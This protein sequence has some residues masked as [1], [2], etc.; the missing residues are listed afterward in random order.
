[1]NKKK[2]KTRDYIAIAITI[3]I[4]III[5]LIGRVIY[6]NIVYKNVAPNIE[7]VGSK[8]MTINLNEEYSEPGV[9]AYDYID[10]NISKKAIIKGEV[11]TQKIGT[12]YLYYSVENS[13]NIKSDE[14]IRLVKVI[15]SSLIDTKDKSS[16]N[17][18]NN[19]KSPKGEDAL[20]EIITEVINKH[21]DELTQFG[22][23]TCKMVDYLTPYIHAY[24]EEDEYPQREV[25]RPMVRASL[26]KID[27]K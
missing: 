4:L 17:N 19:K 14:I 6:K 8:V 11:N 26:E 23:D 21:K 22:T 10:N 3:V 16:E 9:K 27:I 2:N 5:L 12:Y 1:M 15:D 13:R 25:L 20:K 7:L 24:Y 18:S